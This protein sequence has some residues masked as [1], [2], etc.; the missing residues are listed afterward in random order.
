[1]QAEIQ[2]EDAENAVRLETKFTSPDALTDIIEIK[3]VS[4]DSVTLTCNYETSRIVTFASI[5]DAKRFI[6]V[7]QG[8]IEAV[9]AAVVRLSNINAGND[10]I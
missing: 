7:F 4:N 2:I 6:L 9:Q 10:R 5:E 8:A 1:M 3:V